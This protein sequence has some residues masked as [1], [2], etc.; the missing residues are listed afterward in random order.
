MMGQHAACLMVDIHV[1]LILMVDIH[2]I[3]RK[4]LL[5]C[6]MPS[7]QLCGP[8]ASLLSGS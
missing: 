2:V 7:W 4:G 8:A 1:I 3:L 5:G 6:I